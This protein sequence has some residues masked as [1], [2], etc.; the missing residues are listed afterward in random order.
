MPSLVKVANKAIYR[1]VTSQ[2]LLKISAH[3]NRLSSGQA[4][5]SFPF[6]SL[7]GF[8]TSLGDVA[9]PKEPI[10]GYVYGGGAGAGTV[11]RLHAEAVYI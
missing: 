7:P 6:D 9:V 5:S 8:V 1:C 10:G 11:W 4:S 2:S 3:S